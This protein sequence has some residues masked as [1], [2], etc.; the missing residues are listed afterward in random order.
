ME[1]QDVFVPSSRGAVGTTAA[2]NTECCWA[3]QSCAEP[4]GE[5][6]HQRKARNGGSQ[7]S[8]FCEDTKMPALPV[9]RVM[10][11]L[12]HEMAMRRDLQVRHHSVGKD[13]VLGLPPSI[14]L[15]DGEE[16]PYGS[17]KRLQIRNNDQESE[18]YQK[19]IRP[20]PNRTVFDG[21]S[22]PPYR[23]SSAGMLGSGDP[24]D[25]SSGGSSTTRVVRCNSVSSGS[26]SSWST[27]TTCT[28]A[29]I[30]PSGSRRLSAFS[31]SS[32][33]GA[34]ANLTMVPC[35]AEPNR[36]PTPPPSPHGAV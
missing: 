7:M 26:F 11:R 17:S 18:I 27:K 6:R 34:L 31:D 8:T 36:V 29:V 12:S 10:D 28:P 24:G 22:P 2:Q 23:T 15:P 19:C 1:E 3:K 16:I 21:E 33:G 9:P 32:S 13:L 20:P 4:S 30:V 35:D 25:W 5:R 14:A